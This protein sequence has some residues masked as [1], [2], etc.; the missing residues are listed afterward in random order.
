MTQKR[1]AYLGWLGITLTCIVYAPMASEYM[2][3]FYNFANMQL[4][5]RLYAMIVGKQQALGAG[6][7][8]AE[9]HDVYMQSRLPL[10]VH[11]SLGGIIILIAASQFSRGLRQRYL[12]VHRWAGRVLVVLATISMLTAIMYLVRTGPVGTFSGPPFYAQLW[13]LALG[14]LASVWAGFLAIRL[15]E[16]NLHQ[17][18]MAYAF[19]LLL[20]APLLRLLW[21]GFGLAWPDVTQDFLNVAGGTTLGLLAPGGAIVASRVL[22][23]R[24]Q[25]PIGHRPMPGIGLEVFIGTLALVAAAWLVIHYQNQIGKVDRLLMTLILAFSAVLATFSM[26]AMSAR[27]QGKVLATEEWRIH[28]LA[29]LCCL[30]LYAVMWAAY[31]VFF[32][33]VESFYSAALTSPAAAMSAGFFLV[34]WRRW[35]PASVAG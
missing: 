19:A 11:T 20:T 15:R 23:S 7:V 22:D 2:F 27:Q 8:F 4:W 16:I 25:V 18:L 5:D 32:T 10:L 21:L 35:Q 17:C 9:Q 31:A 24:T 1:W 13:A 28:S 30:P 33:P 26:L 34:L 12:K 29:L 6:S 14:T 3:R